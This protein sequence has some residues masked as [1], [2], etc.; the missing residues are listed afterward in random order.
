MGSPRGCVSPC[1]NSQDAIL[2]PLLSP[3]RCP[4]PPPAESIYETVE[5]EIRDI[6]L[7]AVEGFTPICVLLR[8]VFAMPPLLLPV[9]VSPSSPKNPPRVAPRDAGRSLRMDTLL[10]PQVPARTNSR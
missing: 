9:A 8:L 5:F 7:R 4:S 10:A 2:L 6:R 1:E 3:V